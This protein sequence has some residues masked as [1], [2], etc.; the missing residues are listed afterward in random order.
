MVIILLTTI[1]YMYLLSFYLI[2]VQKPGFFSGLC[3]GFISFA[4][5]AYLII[6]EYVPKH[7][8]DV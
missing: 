3:V 5:S 7:F 4:I 1:I 8:S 2:V 6:N